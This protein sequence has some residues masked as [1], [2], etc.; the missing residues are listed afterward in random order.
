[1]NEEGILISIVILILIGIIGIFPPMICLVGP[2]TVFLIIN[3]ILIVFRTTTEFPNCTLYSEKNN[4]K[5]EVLKKEERKS[6]KTSSLK[7]NN[8]HR[9]I[10]LKLRV[11]NNNKQNKQ[12]ILCLKEQNFKL[13]TDNGTIYSYVSKFTHPDY[14]SPNNQTTLWIY[15]EVPNYENFKSLKFDFEW[16]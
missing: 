3:L 4:A 9:Y 6:K 7:A 14:I 5:V 16:E 10:Y 12:N 8:G 11:T 1:M 13:L 15:Y 2:L